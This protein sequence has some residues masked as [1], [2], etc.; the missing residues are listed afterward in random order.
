MKPVTVREENDYGSGKNR[1]PVQYSELGRWPDFIGLGV[2]KCGT[3]WLYDMLSQLPEI[4]FAQ[5]DRENEFCYGTPELVK[6][7]KENHFPLKEVQYWNP[8]YY[9]FN[10]KK[11]FYPAYKALFAHAKPDQIAGEITNNYLLFLLDPNILDAFH[12]NMPSVKIFVVLR[13]PVDRYISHHFFQHDIGQINRSLGIMDGYYSKGNFPSL[14][15][16]IDT[17]ISWTKVSKAKDPFNPL[18]VRFFV[19]GLY[20]ICI[21]NIMKRY[22][23]SQLH[24]IQF[25][26]I[27]EKPEFVLK[28]LCLFLGIDPDFQFK[29]PE[30][31]SNLTKTPKPDV[32]EE[33]KV[34]GE[35][36]RSSIMQ[37]SGML[38]RNLEHWLK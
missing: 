34:L 36:Y 29:R 14:R 15:S 8:F 2:A 30:K 25:D 23:K 38:N 5:A 26:D 17:I 7:K 21:Q 6:L 31:P 22:D 18:A 11:Q 1:V 35:L 9:P 19:M 27:K 13:N 24:I 12:S 20:S 32:S 33:R 10:V 37:L 4:C 3:T 16:D 28:K